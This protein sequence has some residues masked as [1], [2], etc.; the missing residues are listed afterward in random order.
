[1]TISNFNYANPAFGTSPT[2]L[3]LFQDATS[4]GPSTA[5][6][7]TFPQKRATLKFWGT[8]GGATVIFQTGVPILESGDVG[9][10]V[11]ILNASTG[12]TFSFTSDGNVTLE[13]MVSGDLFRAVISGATGTTSLSVTAQGV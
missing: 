9:Y 6:S 11:P 2:N 4:N 10:F 8:W 3:V 12:S 13:N 5:Y 1:M 7:F